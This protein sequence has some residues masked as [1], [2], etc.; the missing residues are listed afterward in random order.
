MGTFAVIRL[1]SVRNMH[2]RLPA[3]LKGLT[4]LNRDQFTQTIIVPAVKVPVEWIQTAKWK[5][6]LLSLPALKT[7]R[8]LEATSKTHKQVLFDPD[9]IKSKDDLIEQIPAIR[10]YADESFEMTSLTITY[11]NYSIDQVIKAILP[12]EL[13]KDKP[14]NTGSGYSLIGHI[15]HFNLKDEVLPYKH[16]IGEFSEARDQHQ[17]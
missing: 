1:Q 9:L 10:S 13:A 12:D 14:V 15:A 16:V 2:L 7:V 3:T 11:A 5:K 4:H 6:A 8:D 17:C